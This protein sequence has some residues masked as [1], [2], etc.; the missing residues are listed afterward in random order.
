MSARFS[1]IVRSFA[2]ISSL[3]GA[4]LA[5]PSN[6][7]AQASLGEGRR[8]ATRAELEQAAKA[9]EQAATVAPD[10]KTRDKLL[11]DATALRQRLR[12]GDFL[13]GDRIYIVVLGDSALTDTFTVR[14]DRRLQLPNIPDVTLSGVLDSELNT[15]LTTELSRY[16]KNPTV[17]A[18]GMVRLTL[19]GGIARNGFLTFPVDQAITDV[20][21]TAGGIG[22]GSKLDEAEVKR[23]GKTFIDK[24][25]F[26]EAI[27]LARTVGDL[28]LRDG[29]EV[30]VPAATA[31]SGIQGWVKVLGVLGPLFLLIRL[32]TNNTGR[33]RN[34]P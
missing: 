16:L 5:V 10:T 7:E 15:F 32:V 2:F 18:T 14:G 11:A 34:L 24:K 1:D 28:A 30:Y 9:T 26:Q 33:N 27:R 3:A 25:A 6:A 19:T 17:T 4:L 23:A 21:M 31:T 20:L 22:P 13:P 12:N 29:D 8:Q